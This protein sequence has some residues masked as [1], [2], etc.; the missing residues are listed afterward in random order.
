MRNIGFLKLCLSTKGDN[1]QILC[2]YRR[3]CN[4]MKEF[5]YRTL[6]AHL[7]SR[8][9][10]RFLSKIQKIHTFS[11]FNLQTIN[12]QKL[13]FENSVRFRRTLFKH[14]ETFFVPYNRSLQFLINCKLAIPAIQ[15]F[16]RVCK[17]DSRKLLKLENVLQSG[18]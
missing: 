9:R 13:E 15:M 18:I 12:P 17:R 6:Q 10:G 5:E 16:R 4:K 11:V 7:L 14:R 8:P 2:S 3:P 1:Q